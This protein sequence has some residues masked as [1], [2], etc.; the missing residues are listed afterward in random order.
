[1][2]YSSSPYSSFARKARLAATICVAV[3][4]T[5]A[6]AAKRIPVNAEK[7][8]KTVPPGF[9]ES[10][11]ASMYKDATGLT[12]AHRTLPKGTKLIVTNS[13]NDK[14]VCVTVADRGPYIEGR[15]VDL[16]YAASAVIG[17]TRKQGVV[18][19]TIKAVDACP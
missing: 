2:E 12:T 17:L 13:E 8:M 6:D 9:T 5:P 19:V 16:S 4:A 1:M 7:P 14:S 11:I 10:G 18:P 3:F 15:I